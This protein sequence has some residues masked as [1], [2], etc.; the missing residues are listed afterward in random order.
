MIACFPVYRSYV[1]R[2]ASSEPTDRRSSRAVR[3]ATARNPLL[4]RA[5]FDFIRDTLLLQDPPSGPAPTEYRAA[6]RR[7]AGKFQQVTAPVMAKGVEDTAFYVYN[8]LLSLNE[9][10]GDP[11]RF[12][13]AAGASS[14]RYLAEPAANVARA[15]CRR[16]RRTTP[17]AA[18]TCGRGSTCCPRCPTSGPRACSRWAELNRAAPG[19]DRTTGARP[20]ANEEYLLYQTLVGA[21]PLE[22][23]TADESDDVRRPRSRRT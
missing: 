17:S 7:F 2:R 13:A 21:W 14:T 12:G 22:R 10:G 6:Q 15:A 18:R 11:G 19:R 20:D 23:L 8:R 1:E 5:V 3:R 4:G 16:S 9:V